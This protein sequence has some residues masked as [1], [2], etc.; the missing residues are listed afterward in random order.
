MPTY[1]Q[2]LFDYFMGRSEDAEKRAEYIR[3]GL[4]PT[5]NLS[6]LIVDEPEAELAPGI[7]NPSDY[8]QQSYGHLVIALREN[9][10]E[11]WARAK[12]VAANTEAVQ[13]EYWDTMVSQG[14]E[15]AEARELAAQ[16]EGVGWTKAEVYTEVMHIL[17]PQ[18]EVEGLDPLDICQ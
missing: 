2:R 10:P 11:L 14:A 9:Q 1:E 15:S 5:N 18:M 13:R 17:G 12:E 4:I 16:V 3:R 6:L 8:R 7:P